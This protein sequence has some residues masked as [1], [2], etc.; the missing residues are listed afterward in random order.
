MEQSLEIQTREPLQV[1]GDYLNFL[2][3]EPLSPAA[4]QDFDSIELE[5]IDVL[6]PGKELEG[7]ELRAWE[8]RQQGVHMRNLQAS[9]IN[10]EISQADWHHIISDEQ[11]GSVNTRIQAV[12]ELVGH[13]VRGGAIQGEALLEVM[14]D[15]FKTIEG[16]GHYKHFPYRE[17]KQMKAAIVE[18]ISNSNIENRESAQEAVILLDS[19]CHPF[20]QFCSNMIF[21]A[22]GVVP[23]SQQDR[24]SSY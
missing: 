24:K 15:C 19:F 1:V 11:Q 18:D 12:K 21:K 8:V 13:V 3:T 16:I 5:I 9:Y 20:M 14:D 7:I 23:R 4:D 22:W 2:R 10:K 17:A 6:Y